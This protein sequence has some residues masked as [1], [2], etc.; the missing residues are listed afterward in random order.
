[1]NGLQLVG[2]L[3]TSSCAGAEAISELPAAVS[4]LQ[5]RADTAGDIPASWLRNHFHGKLLYSLRSLRCGGKFSGSCNERHSRLAAAAQEFDLIELEA[6]SDLSS[7][8]LQHIPAERRAILQCTPPCDAAQLRTTFEQLASIPANTYCLI[9]ASSKTSDGLQ[10]LLFLK[11]LGRKDVVA[12]SEGLFGL[13]S[14]LLS[15]YFGAPFLIGRIGERNSTVDDLT[16]EQ[17]LIDYGFPALGALEKLYGIAGNPVLQSLSPR[18]HNAGYRAIRYPALF[19]PFHVDCFE[20]FWHEMLEGSALQFLGIPIKGLTIV[21]PYKEVAVAAAG[22]SSSMVRRAAS[23]NI[24]MRKNGVWKADTTDPESIALL[25]SKP[26]Q[27]LETIKAAV[28]GCGGAGRAVAAALKDAGAEVTLVNRG[29]DRGTR[30]CRLL[31][32]PFVSLSEFKAQGFTLVV[33]ATPIGRQNDGPPFEIDSLNSDAVIVDLAYGVNPTPL[34]S[35]ILARGGRAVDGH[36]VLL[37]QVR[38]QFMLMV[39]KEMPDVVGRKL[40]YANRS[41]NFLVNDAGMEV[42][43]ST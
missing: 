29:Q 43:A 21:S 17:L 5:L 25:S 37:H 24:F 3:T 32:L 7:K 30:A 23:T 20:D 9:S 35:G 38:K 11:A 26:G 41:P 16:V 10:P 33:N 36:E 28:I 40:T 8:L 6:D 15:P 13:W 14:R 4:W 42:A 22:Q 19:V 18:L 31:G 1:M 27:P 12:F 34:V 2:A 39:G